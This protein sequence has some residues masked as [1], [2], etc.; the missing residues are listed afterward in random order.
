MFDLIGNEILHGTDDLNTWLWSFWNSPIWLKFSTV[1][2]MSC[3]FFILYSFDRFSVNSIMIRYSFGEFISV[4]YC[5]FWAQILYF[6]LDIMSI[7][8]SEG[9]RYFNAHLLYGQQW[10]FFITCM[11][12]NCCRRAFSQ[13]SGHIYT[14]FWWCQNY[15]CYF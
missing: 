4:L 2:S 10:G 11:V 13:T 8:R 5:Y 15:A 3:L 1:L 7:A 6:R 14:L 12:I 9:P